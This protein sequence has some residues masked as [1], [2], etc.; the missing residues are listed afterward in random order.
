MAPFLGTMFRTPGPCLGNSQ[1]RFPHTCGLFFAAL[2][3]L[4]PFSTLSSSLLV[5][6]CILIER[7]AVTCCA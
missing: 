5:T 4:W 7:M 2:R 3:R 6:A 1:P